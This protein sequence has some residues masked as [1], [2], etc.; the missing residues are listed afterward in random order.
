MRW[1]DS[2]YGKPYASDDPLE[3]EAKP[4]EAAFFS[5]TE[6]EASNPS[7]KPN[8]FTPISAADRLRPQRRTGSRV[9]TQ[10]PR[11]PMQPGQRYGYGMPMPEA[12]PVDEPGR[13]EA[14]PPRAPAYEAEDID[15]Y[16]RRYWEELQHQEAAP[17]SWPQ[18][19]F[20]PAYLQGAHP[21]PMYSEPVY[22]GNA[23]GAPSNADNLYADGSFS[24]AP[25]PD[26]AYTTYPSAGEMDWLSEEL[27]GEGQIG[28]VLAQDW[29]IPPPG[30]RLNS[31]F[32]EPGPAPVLPEGNGFFPPIASPEGMSYP[33]MEEPP[34]KTAPL[35][36]AIHKLRELAL[37]RTPEE[38]IPGRMVWMLG[39]GLMTLALVV[40]VFQIGRIVLNV[41]QNDEEMKSVREEY[42]ALTGAELASNADRVELLPAGQTFVPTATPVPAFTPMP[43]QGPQG[44][45]VGT[46]AV[47][48][49]NPQPTSPEAAPQAQRTKAGKYENN[50][51][52]AVAPEFSE[53]LQNNP[54]VVGRL[55][56]EGLVDETV[57]K[58]NNTYYLNHNA[59]GASHAAGAVFVDES[60]QIASPPENLLLRGQSTVEGKMFSPL[61]RYQSEGAE[62]V[63][64]HALLTM[65]TLYEPGR[66]V[67]FAV[68]V[69]G[70]APGSDAF[71]YAGY[72]SF[73]SD[74]Q[75]E[76]FVAKAKEHS[77]YE[78]PVEV[79]PTD[80]LL[81]LSTLAGG[82][83]TNTLVL[84]AR[85]L[86][87]GETD[88]N[89]S[90]I[91][92]AVRGR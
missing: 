9:R 12:S 87:A 35:S 24:E 67:V 23:Y 79:V 13:E 64:Q 31:D 28:D 51:L 54:D 46:E 39:M 62:F 83:E 41:M 85:K 15:A 3:P 60:C 44:V 76:R 37:K 45:A 72:P 42:Y 92:A 66:Y 81:T 4:P 40:M 16:Q 7:E 30:P 33:P 29:M 25:Y 70:T 18:E 80:R 17:Q 61:W 58:R 19:S 59:R 26:P 90:K 50:P 20:V 21:P 6:E 1:E 8:V 27:A 53:L 55:H 68:L 10:A 22:P 56:I 77:L 5:P 2:A 32:S 43:D 11:M 91:L 75:M 52:K 47:A 48:S 69:Q 49:A 65:D 34:P 73:E 78:I 71:N 36:R 82:K 63:K 84:M 86:R 74:Q 88:A 57:V 89:F 38:K 14:P